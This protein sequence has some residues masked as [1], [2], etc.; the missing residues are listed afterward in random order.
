MSTSLKRYKI[1]DKEELC[2]VKNYSPID[3]ILQSNSCEFEFPDKTTAVSYM[4]NIDSKNAITA[5]P[6]TSHAGH[7]RI[8]MPDEWDEE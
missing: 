7:S 4:L 3:G 1:N 5:T 8:N 2:G 6:L